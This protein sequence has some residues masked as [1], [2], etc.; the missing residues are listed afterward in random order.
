MDALLLMW[1][2]YI[3]LH[4]TDA[5][6]EPIFQS[7]RIFFL[8]G[9]HVF[10][11]YIR[12]RDSFFSGVRFLTSTTIDAVALPLFSPQGNFVLRSMGLL[13][14]SL[15]VVC[16]ER[17]SPQE[18]FSSRSA[19]YRYRRHGSCHDWRYCSCARPAMIAR[20]TALGV[21]LAEKKPPVYETLAA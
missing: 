17:F 2:A 4:S 18:P 1:A 10:Y 3:R 9:A 14:C 7:G 5:S 15:D 8:G 21:R 11:E 20:G 12:P 13:R 6:S 19:L 16:S